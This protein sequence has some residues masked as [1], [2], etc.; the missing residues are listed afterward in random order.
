MPPALDSKKLEATADRVHGRI[1]SEFPGSGLAEVAEAVVAATRDA[2]RRAA[3]IA[4]PNRWLRAGQALLVAIAAA[5]VAVYFQAGA[6]GAGF[7]KALLEFLDAAKANFALLLAAG[8]F[9]FTL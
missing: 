3:A 9:L 4:R 8:V 2:S 1:K 7:G 6:G 5:G